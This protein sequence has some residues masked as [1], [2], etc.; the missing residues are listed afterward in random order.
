MGSVRK[1]I[2]VTKFDGRRQPFDKQKVFNTCVR[3][4]ATPEA[5]QDIADKVEQ[6]AYDGI[7]T[8][9]V[10]RLVFAFLRKYNPEIRHVTDLRT[11]ISMLRPKPDFE[12]FVAQLL[13]AYGHEVKSNQM[14]RG[15]CVE[16]EIDAIAEKGGRIFYVE[17]KHHYKPHTYTSLDVFL[18]AR[19]TFEDLC[20]GYKNGNNKIK[21]DK[22]IVVSNTKLSDHAKMYAECRGIDYIAWK[23]PIDR[24][25][26]RMIEEKKMYPI[27]LLRELDVDIE[28]RLGD[29]GIVT[30][31]QLAEMSESEIRRMT[32]I[33]K[34]TVR[35]LKKKAT[36]FG[37]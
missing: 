16:H 31:K 28:A 35:E 9:E 32:N 12:L 4:H 25:L 29:A 1:Q 10:L 30:L 19:A 3:M 37:T 8:K 24:G 26:E 13:R 17:V 23:A 22:A 5:A 21:F 27:T 2:S 33:P 14:V 34:K 11:A 18:E 6:R 20:E 7:P 15:M 36:V